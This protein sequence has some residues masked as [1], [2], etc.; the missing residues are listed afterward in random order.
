M[1]NHIEGSVYVVL[2]RKCDVW[3]LTYR[4]KCMETHI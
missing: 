2:Y 4:V 1:G 3:R